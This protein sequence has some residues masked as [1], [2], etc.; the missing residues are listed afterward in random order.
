[1]RSA[2]PQPAMRLPAMRPVRRRS[3][4]PMRPIVMRARHEFNI[5]VRKL[6]R[7]LKNIITVCVESGPESRYPEHNDANGV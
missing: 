4:L 3:S 6:E 1:M 5:L 2:R 7:I